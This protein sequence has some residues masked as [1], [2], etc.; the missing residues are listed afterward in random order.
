M[1]DRLFLAHPRSIGES[2]PEH[3]AMAARFGATMVVGGLACIVHAVFPAVFATTASDRVKQLYRQMKAR[4][5]AFKA[6]PPAFSDPAWQLEY[7][8]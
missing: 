3:A 1:F 6:Q 8:I 4:Q 5:P 2:Y 7:E